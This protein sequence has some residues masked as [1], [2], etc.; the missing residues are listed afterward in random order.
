MLT[1]AQTPLKQAIVSFE[2]KNLTEFKPKRTFYES[3][4]INRIRFW[5]LVEGSKVPDVNEARRL[6]EHFNIPL[7][8]FF[9][10]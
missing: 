9:Q 5:Q 7:A 6:S 4:K 8:N 2:D 10:S 3:V 1:N